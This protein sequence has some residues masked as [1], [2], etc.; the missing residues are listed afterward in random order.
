MSH[1]HQP[2]A[3]TTKATTSDYQHSIPSTL[4]PSVL[5]IQSFA[6]GYSLDLNSP[7]SIAP[8]SFNRAQQTRGSSFWRER[9]GRS[10]MTITVS[11]HCK[12]K[13]RKAT[14]LFSIL[15]ELLNCII[16]APIHKTIE[17][18]CIQMQERSC[19]KAPTTTVSQLGELQVEVCIL[20]LSDQAVKSSCSGAGTLHTCHLCLPALPAA[21]FCIS[22][23][24]I[25]SGYFTNY[26]VLNS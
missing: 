7:Y 21:D 12:E 17:F 23:Q 4:N 2:P 24:K 26:L 16:M 11:Q 20:T 6:E 3:S 14:Y 22:R 19:T 8:Q 18:C 13:T 9:R 5:E 1:L 15:S 10:T 25:G